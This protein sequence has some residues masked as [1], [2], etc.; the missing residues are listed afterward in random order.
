[1]GS[2]MC[3]RDRPDYGQQQYRVSLAGISR[4]DGVKHRHSRVLCVSNGTGGSL[5]VP[6]HQQEAAAKGGQTARNRKSRPRGW[7]CAASAPHPVDPDMEPWWST[8]WNCLP[9][10]GT[11]P[12]RRAPLH[13]G[14]GKASRRT[15]IPEGSLEIDGGPG[16]HT[17]LPQAGDKSCSRG[18]SQGRQQSGRRRTRRYHHGKSWK[19]KR[20]AS[21][22]NHKLVPD[23]PTW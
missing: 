8:P 15:G 21:W 16:G 19:A 10:R 23:L 13:P 17:A 2:E 7:H 18:A 22:T 9:H 3:I 12:P 11:H 14:N 5:P 1:M 20:P 4:A 6:P